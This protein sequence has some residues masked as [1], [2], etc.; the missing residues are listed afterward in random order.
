MEWV[1]VSD[2]FFHFLFLAG[3]CGGMIGWLVEFSGT[4]GNFH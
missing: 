2:H 3:F 1:E 4:W